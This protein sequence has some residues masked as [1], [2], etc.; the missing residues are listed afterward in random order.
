[1][2]ALPTSSVDGRRRWL[3]RF[4]AVKALAD[5]PL[6]DVLALWE[7]LGYYSRARNLRKAAQKVMAEYGGRLPRDTASLGLTRMIQ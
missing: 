4:P 7:G 5:A 1:V 6:G 2:S 3:K